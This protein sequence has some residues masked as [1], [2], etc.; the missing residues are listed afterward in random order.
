MR[1]ALV[2]NFQVNSLNY[3]EINVFFL[4]SEFSQC[5]INK[6]PQFCKYLTKKLVKFSMHT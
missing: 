5:H 2:I 3:F 6:R 4:I 1:K